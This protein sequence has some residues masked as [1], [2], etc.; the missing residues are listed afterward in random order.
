MLSWY[1]MLPHTHT[2]RSRYIIC[3]I[4]SRRMI[5]RGK[6]NYTRHQAL[7]CIS[8]SFNIML[9]GKWPMQEFDDTCRQIPSAAYRQESAGNEL[10]T[11]FVCAYAGTTGDQKWLLHAYQFDRNWM[12][13]SVCWECMA[14][15]VDPELLYTNTDDNTG[16]ALTEGQYANF[17][18]PL[19]QVGGWCVTTVWKDSLHLLFVNGVGNDFV[20]SAL[21]QTSKEGFWNPASDKLEPNLVSA[22]GKFLSWCRLNGSETTH[23]GF[24]RNS[25]HYTKGNMYPWLAGKAADVRLVVM[26]MASELNA[27]QGQFPLLSRCMIALANYLH[28]MSKAGPLLEKH[29]SALLRESGTMFVQSY[30]TLAAQHVELGRTLYKIR[31]KLHGLMHLIKQTNTLNPKLTSCWANEDYMGRISRVASRTHRRT[32]TLR[33]LQRYLFALAR[34]IFKCTAQSDTCGTQRLLVKNGGSAD[35]MCLFV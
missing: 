2:V 12:C 34:E 18:S 21:V 10:A 24:T 26:W 3:A 29:E 1:G 32:T 27:A 17:D 30:L 13:N 9:S 20:A 15:K 35:H 11:G 14:S 19:Q 31:P 25:L 8:W 28:T 4:P 6:Q 7:S 16:W 22:Y 23:D 5:H 33:V